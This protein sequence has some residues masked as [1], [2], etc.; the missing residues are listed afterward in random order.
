MGPSS[1]LVR[2]V[3]LVL[4]ALA[5]SA[6]LAQQSASPKRV[7]VLH[8]YDRGYTDDI[9]LDQELHAALESSAPGRVE[10]YSEYLDTNQFPGEKQALIL[11]DYL[12]RKYAGVTIDVVIALT[13]PPLDFLLKYRSEL[14]PHTPIVF[15]I[16][17]VAPAH[18]MPEA[19]TTG[20]VTANTFRKTVDMALK[21]HPGTKQLFVI[22]G[23]LDHDK[24]REAAARTE[25]KGFEDKVVITYLTDLS[26]EEL[27]RKLKDPPKNSIALYVW[28]QVLN[29]EGNVLESG[30]VV[31]RIAR[32]AVIPLY[33]MSPSYIGLGM[34]GGYVWTLEANATK[35]AEIARRVANG[36]RPEDIP[37]ENAPETSMFDWR[38]VQ[39]W[40]IR[41]DRLPPGSV[42]QFREPTVWQQY[43]WRIVA[44]LVIFILQSSLIGALLL[45]RRRARLRAL[46]LISA[47]QE[48][49]ES[50]ERFRNIANTAP[51]M[52]AIADS[53]RRATFF[54]KGWLDF[55]GRT[56]EQ[57]LGQGW[58]GGLHPDDREECLAK[59][60]ASYEA[61]S[62]C[63]LEYRLRRAD[64]EYRSLLCSGVPRFE[65]D[66]AF[67]GYVASIIDIT[68]LKRGQ[69]KALASQKLQSLGVLAGGVAHD[70]NNLL[71]GI[72][73]NSE[74]LISDFTDSPR[75]QEGVQTIKVI[76]MRA[77][78]IVRQ[79]MVYAGHE[80]TLFEDVDLADS[81]REML[82][83][84]LVS[85]S[86]SAALKIDVP[87][88]VPMIRAN[89]A[90]LRQVFMNL[91]TNA[92]DALGDERGEICVTLKQV[93]S[94]GEP[95][96]GRWP[97]PL[98]ADWL[99]LEVR[100]S[101]RGMTEEVQARIFD[102]F[103]S[104]KGVGR[105]MGLS[106]VQ[107][108]IRSHGGTINVASK[109]G[110]GTCFEI[111]LPCASQQEQQSSDVGRSRLACEPQGRT[112]TV[113]IID[114][115]YSLRVPVA[116]MLKKR[117]FSV[118]EAADGETGVSLFREHPREIDVVLLDLT[119][120]GISGMEVLKEMRKQRSNIKVILATAY[121]RDRALTD[122]SEKESVSYVQKPYQID[123]LEALLRKNCFEEPEVKQAGAS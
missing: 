8:W 104:T 101:G 115:E 98:V 83:L 21:L 79:L 16:A 107:G 114:D 75:V 61:R 36:E 90:Q 80:S 60:S 102:P 27:R 49:R 29:R 38:Q 34:T 20:I 106:A 24:S 73:A 105:G 42:I 22:S 55:T 17:A 33:G 9:K 54:N 50:E 84:I 82:S 62:E 66:G 77:S 113:L 6:G 85:I 109:L 7:L 118:F 23:T 25:L 69:E 123:A 35:L 93:R 96:I 78:E 92:S 56:V 40:G 30:D 86:K 58:T 59:I 88:N 2:T 31:S 111:R 70:F 108:I 100:D 11:R 14:F 122:V 71:G 52:I 19:G 44:A 99:R 95:P 41:E 87:D 53:E 116:R 28:Q 10:Y 121:G 91:I 103:F 39:R 47:Q 97:Q 43:R 48:V 64:G 15:S 18:K 63:D 81:V 26:A 72:L 76:A 37:I 3:L 67:A 13:N 51:V 89:N 65:R 5:P 112:G 119:L 12:R 1:K 46:A 45:E 117:G 120:P 74:L 68:E 4:V 32:E 94:Q 57:E 110:E